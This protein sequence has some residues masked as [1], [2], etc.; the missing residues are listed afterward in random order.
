VIDILA[1][2]AEKTELQDRPA[3]ESLQA[4]R[5]AGLFALRTPVAHGGAW[6]DATDIARR[7]AAAGRACPSTAWIAGTCLTSKTLAAD[8]FPELES[9]FAD[10]DALF[11]GSGTPSGVGETTPS[12]IRI[13]GQWEVVSGCEDA[14]WAGFGAMVDGKFSLVQIPLS[15]LH[16]ERTWQMAGMRGTGSH[17]VIARDVLIPAT[18]AAP[19]N[20][21]S[22]L[23]ALQV[24]GLAVLAPIVG[25][26][27]GALDV[28]HAMFE[29]DRKPHMTAYTS[30]KESPGARQWLAE[31]STLASRAERTMLEVAAR[32]DSGDP[33]DPATASRL[34]LNLSESARDCRAAV[35]LML[36]LHGA[37]GLKASNPLQ[38]FWRDVA[39]G[40]RHP[41]LNP[42]LAMEGYGKV[43]SGFTG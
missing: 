38:R 22:D 41:H 11:C 3:A 43:V 25:A 42:Y 34:H 6:A 21:G 28:V 10:P 13:N 27:H 29:S 36:D 5:E 31:A 8:A 39:V 23:A 17:R 16:I 32:I 37:S 4:A 14:T 18:H 20:L 2:N 19:L 30:M 24:F 9:L 1:A 26:T 33:V 35:E 7:L 12:G 40:S 15:Q